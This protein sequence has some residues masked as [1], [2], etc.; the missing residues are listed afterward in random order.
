MKV[1]FDIDDT[2]YKIVKRVRPTNANAVLMNLN[3]DQLEQIPD[4]DLIQVLKWFYANGDTI[5][6]WSAG[7]IDYAQLVIN[8][9]G[10]N[11]CVHKVIRKDS[12]S[13]SENGIELA[14]DDEELTITGVRSI[15]VRRDK[16]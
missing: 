8:K 16:I 15:R 5:Y 12:A 11:G 13:A 3:G 6:A 2:L 7:G 9:L 4:Y 14:F 1:V 10:L